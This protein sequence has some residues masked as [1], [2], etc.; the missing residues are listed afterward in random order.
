MLE[1]Q[2]QE[3]NIKPSFFSRPPQYP[4]EV[5]SVYR[6]KFS[7]LM[8]DKPFTKPFYARDDRR[9]VEK[10][11]VAT[12]DGD[13]IPMAGTCN[14]T[15]QKLS[16]SIGCDAKFPSFT[17]SGG[18][19]CSGGDNSLD[20]DV[21]IDVSVDLQPSECA[22]GPIDSQPILISENAKT[23]DYLDQKF[24]PLIETDK[25][26]EPDMHPSND[27][28]TSQAAESN[29][30]CVTNNVTLSIMELPSSV[31]VP[32]SYTIPPVILSNNVAAFSS[33]SV[34]SLVTPMLTPQVFLQGQQQQHPRKQFPTSKNK[35][36]NSIPPVFQE[37]G[38]YGVSLPQNG[39]SKEYYVMVHVEA[40]AT[41]SIRTGDQ[42]QQ[43]PG[44][45]L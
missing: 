17:S 35:N 8:T 44:N 36:P 42:E 10:I 38:L 29:D 24:V 16:S 32:P 43:I 25:L 39:A 7:N 1:D 12:K 28:T 3:N 2:P 19:R 9:S 23:P 21:G 13:S 45:F 26:S 31:Y 30:L 6:P 33:S 27:P 15:E 4:L 34:E 41:F 11:S 20:G 5:N 22:R 40:G 14:A 18:S 37:N